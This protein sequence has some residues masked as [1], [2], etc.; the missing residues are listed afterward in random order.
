MTTVTI[1]DG[2]K[3]ELLDIESLS[4]EQ[5]LSLA[6]AMTDF[7]IRSGQIRDDVAIRAPQLVQFMGE[8][9]DMAAQERA[10]AQAADDGRLVLK[11]SAEIFSSRRG[12]KYVELALSEPYDHSVRIVVNA[13]PGQD[14]DDLA[15]ALAILQV[16][17]VINA[18]RT[19]DGLAC[20]TDDI[21]RLRP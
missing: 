14:D 12:M 18:S 3:I 2:R 11:G 17:V 19:D 8:A 9:A 13:K 5:T 1:A 6:T 16:P 4:P 10:D 21:A 15:I 20:T 7:L